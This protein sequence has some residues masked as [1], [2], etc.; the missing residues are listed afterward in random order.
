M[1]Q[2]NIVELEKPEGYCTV[3]IYNGDITKIEDVVDLLVVS[4][5]RDSF[6]PT[7]G[8]VLGALYRNLAIDAEQLF[9]SEKYDFRDALNC[10]VTEKIND[11]TFKMLMVVEM[12]ND[13]DVDIDVE[14]IFRNLFITI[15]VFEQMGHKIR[16]IALPP[17]G[18][19]NQM[20]DFSETV[21][22]LLNQLGK[23][24]KNNIGLERVMFVEYNEEKSRKLSKALDK[25]LNRVSFKLPVDK[26]ITDLKKDI[27][28]SIDKNATQ[29]LLG[30]DTFLFLKRT[31]DNPS[32]K[33]VEFG[34]ACRRLAEKFIT[35]MFFADVDSSK[36]SFLQ[37]IRKL[38]ENNVAMWI[39]SYLHLIR[40]FGNEAAHEI[41]DGNVKPRSIAVRDITLLLFSTQRVVEFWV[42]WEA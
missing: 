20:L 18:T 10:W 12:I 21:A 14:K 7:P 41:G 8:T 27:I 4:A 9:L 13:W 42:E 29:E 31:F 26:V 34:L 23:Q 3:E 28:K 5:F 1:E 37:K 19:G 11:Q 39:V 16:T 33:S 17:L 35:D 36:M 6:Y 22:A 15:N 25:T 30:T 2:L 32:A 38:S 40:V 24:L